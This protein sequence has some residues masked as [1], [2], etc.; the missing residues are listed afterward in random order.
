MNE[1]QS[2]AQMYIIISLNTEEVIEYWQKGK[3]SSPCVLHEDIQ[4]DYV[5]EV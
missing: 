1:V 2:E 4:E 5:C 3:S